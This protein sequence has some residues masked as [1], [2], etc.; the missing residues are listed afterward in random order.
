[1]T[2]SGV[3]IQKPDS[4]VDLLI[5]GDRIKSTS[6]DRIIRN[7]EAQIGKE[8]RYASFSTKEFRYRLNVYD[9]LIR[10]ILDFPHEPVLDRI[11]V[12]TTLSA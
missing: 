8:L 4:R 1:M 12:A 2:V 10:D 9:R 5:V 3:F 6:L 7:L 11:G